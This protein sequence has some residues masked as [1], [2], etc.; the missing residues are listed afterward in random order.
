[1]KWIM[2]LSQPIGLFLAENW[3]ELFA[4]CLVMFAVWVVAQVYHLDGD[5]SASDFVDNNEDEG[6]QG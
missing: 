4:L 6:L 1:M 3:A 5:L 2:S